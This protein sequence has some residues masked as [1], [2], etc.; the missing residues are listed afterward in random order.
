MSTIKS[1][2]DKVRIA[3]ANFHE[4]WEQLHNQV[5]AVNS[6][7]LISILA[8]FRDMIKELDNDREFLKMT[9]DILEETEVTYR[10][11]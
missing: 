2:F 8:G 10:K 5:E 11:E 6:Q 3:V 4:L 9:Y 1:E 7:E